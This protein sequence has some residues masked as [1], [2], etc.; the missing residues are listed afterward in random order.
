MN[1]LKKMSLPLF[2]LVLL[3]SACQKDAEIDTTGVDEPTLETETIELNPLVARNGGANGGGLDFDCFSILYPFGMI[4]EDGVEYTIDSEESFIENFENEVLL[5]DFVYPLDIEDIDGNSSSVNNGEELAEAF[6]LCLPDGGWEEGD[7][8][9]YSIG[10]EN[11]CFDL[12]YPVTLVDLDG[13]TIEVSDDEA[14]NSAVAEGLYFFS[15]PLTLISEDDE[16]IVVEDIDGLFEALI[17]CNGF[18]VEDSTFVWET[19][20]EYLG[21][22]MIEFPLEI[23][24]LDGTTVTVNNHEEYCDLMLQGEIAN[25]SFPL[26]LIDE[27]GN[28]TTVAD[29][30]G[31]EELLDE[32]WDFDFP[33]GDGHFELTIIHSGSVSLDPATLDPCYAIVYPLFVDYGDNQLELSDEEAILELL[34]TED[35]EIVDYEMVYPVSLIL[36]DGTT[37]SVSDLEEV[38]DILNE[39][40]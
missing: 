39:C 37:V 10:S 25:Y 13:N 5:V 7:F 9:A 23:D 19:G 15:F 24:L 32:C 30:E 16:T 6:A 36:S 14:L 8:P 18:E 35:P 21:C 33:F 28:V 11:S 27:E 1:F 31:L 38:F 40:L 20:F 22:Y 3:F 26:T 34:Q 12:V 4:D 29:E 17:S 2:L